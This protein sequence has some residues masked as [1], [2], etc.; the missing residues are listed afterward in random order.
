MGSVVI[1]N[2]AY[3]PKEIQVAVGEKLTWTNNDS[4]AH[5]VTADNGEFDS[6]DMDQGG[7]FDQTF[8]G[9]PREIPYHCDYHGGMHGKVIIK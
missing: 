8:K 2:M 5:T 7:T 3:T 1:K 9:P 4:M 6:G